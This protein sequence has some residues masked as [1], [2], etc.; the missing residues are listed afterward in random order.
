MWNGVLGVFIYYHEWTWLYSDLPTTFRLS[1]WYIS[2][3]S[4]SQTNG[5][6]DRCGLQ[7][8]RLCL[9]CEAWTGP[10]CTW[11]KTGILS[12]YQIQ[13]YRSGHRSSKTVV[14]LCLVQSRLGHWLVTQQ[15]S[16]TNRLITSSRLLCVYLSGSGLYRQ[17]LIFRNNQLTSLKSG[18]DINPK[19]SAPTL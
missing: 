3:G 7:I 15:V 5:Q 16:Q 10:W 4:R 18:M 14:L 11:E 1:Q 19:E 17:L 2:R 8:R 6:T 12:S 9:L 13:I